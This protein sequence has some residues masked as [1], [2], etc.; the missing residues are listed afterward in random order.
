MSTIDL[1]TGLT[2]LL[3]RPF[4]NLSNDEDAVRM[5]RHGEPQHYAEA[6]VPGQLASRY[7]LDD[8]IG[9]V[10]IKVTGHR[11]DFQSGQ[12]IRLLGQVT[13]HA[14]YTPGRGGSSASNITISAERIEAADF[15]DVRMSGGIPLGIPDEVPLQLIGQAD[16]DQRG[17]P[18]IVAIQALPVGIYVHAANAM[19]QVRVPHRLPSELAGAMVRLVDGRLYYSRPDAE[20]VSANRK[21]E[22][23]LGARNV[24]RAEERPVASNGRARRSDTAT[25]VLDAPPVEG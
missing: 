23:V 15:A 4:S 17:N 16:D 10:R 25:A 20:D 2:V 21:A 1:Q 19:L 24:V 22:F 12:P 5:N 6:A 8:G 18:G 9:A 14:W 7:S 13:A 3:R 11:P